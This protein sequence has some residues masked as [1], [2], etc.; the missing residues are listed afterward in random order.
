MAAGEVRIRQAVDGD[1]DAVWPL[2][3]DFATSFRP[4]RAAFD[5]VFARLLARE[6]TLLL[7]AV[8]G[9]S[10]VGYL[11]ASTHDTFLA[12]GPVAWVEELM[13]APSLRRGGV[14]RSLMAAAE[15]WAR[16]TGAAYLALASRR[17]GPFYLALGYEES[18]V[19][20]KKTL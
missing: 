10:V 13:V 5:A 19:F 9:G 1:R 18:A 8:D 2:A 3:R 16:E 4:E 7:V 20:F 17:A 6:D 15:A 12:N 14:G 11:L